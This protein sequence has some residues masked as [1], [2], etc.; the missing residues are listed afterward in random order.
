MM[1]EFRDCR[2]N[3]WRATAGHVAIFVDDRGGKP[4]PDQ[5]AL[6][7]RLVTNL[8]AVEALAAHYLDMFVDRARA[9]GR[10]DERWWF[11]EIEVRGLKP[12]TCYLSFTLDGDDGGNW[13]VEIVERR[14]QILPVRFERQQG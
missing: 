2:G 3:G 6:V 13:I 4:D 9:C 8:E 12:G 14:E 11:D 5:V 7:D 10:A 1:L